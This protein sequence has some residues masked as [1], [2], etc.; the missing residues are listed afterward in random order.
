MATAHEIRSLIEKTTTGTHRRR[1]PE[2][3][4]QQVRRYA[5][6]R[7]AQGA[8]WQA[9]TRET[10]F[11]ARQIRGVHCSSSANAASG[12]A[13]DSDLHL[14]CQGLFAADTRNEFHHFRVRKHLQGHLPVT[15][16]ERPE[17][18]AIRLQLEIHTAHVVTMNF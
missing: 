1:I 2:E 7:R 10:A 13:P 5:E 17:E 15:L 8:T 18:Q 9:I 11:E 12:T 14:L 4:K 16:G 3:V 6:R